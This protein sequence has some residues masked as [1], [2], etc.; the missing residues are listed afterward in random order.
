MRDLFPCCHGD[1]HSVEA[2]LQVVAVLVARRHRQ[3]RRQ[4][5]L[6]ALAL[7]PLCGP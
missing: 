1:R 7:E 2:L 6:S 3:L 5:D 4:H